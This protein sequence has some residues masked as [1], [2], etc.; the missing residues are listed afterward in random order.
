[1][2]FNF[3]LQKLLKLF[4]KNLLIIYFQAIQFLLVPIRLEG[5]AVQLCWTQNDDSEFSLIFSFWI[6]FVSATTQQN[7]TK[8]ALLS[9]K[10]QSLIFQLISNA[11]MQR[12]EEDEKKGGGGKLC[13]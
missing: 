8:W 6:L 9:Y 12:V 11:Q 10:F 3:F 1:M 5:R 4:K 13:S 2:F 7:K